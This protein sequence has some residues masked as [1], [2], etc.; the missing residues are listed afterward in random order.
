MRAIVTPDDLKRGDLVD[1][2]WYPCEI[3][4]YS[5]KEAGTDKS[6]NCIFTFK[7]LDGVNK[8]RSANRLFNEKAMGMGKALWKALNFPFDPE[9][10]YEL[11]TELMKQTVGAKLKVY[12]KRGT[13]NK[14]NDYNDPQDFQP[15][16]AKG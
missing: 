12:I 3:S 14:G 10:G 2:G 5:E 7:I 6:I 4:D 11:T 15:L 1:P 9:K 16:D 13:S 8:G